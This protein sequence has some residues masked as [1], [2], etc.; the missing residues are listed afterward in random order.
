MSAEEA[1]PVE[2][3][4]IIETETAVEP[5]AVD[6]ANEACPAEEEQIEL[7]PFEKR[8]YSS[9]GWRIGM[10]V[11]MWLPNRL[12]DLA[13]CFSLGVGLGVDVGFNAQV[14]QL[15]R[16]GASTGGY[17]L[18]D[19]TYRRQ[20]GFAVQSGWDISFLWFGVEDIVRDNVTG[21]MKPY[22]IDAV[23]IQMPFD[24]AYASGCRDY[25]AIGAEIG[26]FSN[27]R[28]Y[29]HPIEIADFI[30]GLFFIDVISNDDLTGPDVR[31]TEYSF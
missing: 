20:V 11:L 31:K 9:P 6:Q 13:D 19:W 27:V 22:W 16:F 7:N 3:V 10:A 30:C 1:A 21:T 2:E 29:I 28:A 17:S 12:L 25:W 15:C 24:S 23:G 5:I 18:I 26:L 4:V 14:T 8:V